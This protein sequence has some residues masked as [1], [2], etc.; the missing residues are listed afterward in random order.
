MDSLLSQATFT[1]VFPMNIRPRPNVSRCF[2]NEYLFIRF[3]RNLRPHDERFQ[4]NLRQH[5]YGG[6]TNKKS[7]AC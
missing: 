5:E 6:I 7:I 3:R 2:E 1:N 4:K